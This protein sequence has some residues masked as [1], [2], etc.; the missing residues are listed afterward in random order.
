M[1]IVAV[2]VSAPFI[3]V[4]AFDDVTV[5]AANSSSGSGVDSSSSRGNVEAETEAETEA[6]SYW[7][8]NAHVYAYVAHM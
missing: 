8:S 6:A 1:S 2:I 3:I 4:V 5:C 7:Q